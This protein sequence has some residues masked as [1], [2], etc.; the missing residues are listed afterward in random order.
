MPL[1]PTRVVNPRLGTYFSI[2]ASGFATLVLVLL[3]LEQLGASDTLIRNVMLLGPLMLYT[4]VGVS[5]STREPFDFFTSGRRVP[6]VFNGLVVAVT[7]AGAT[8]VVAGTGLFFLNGFDAWC[9]VIGLTGGLVVMSVL[10]AP[11]IR[12]F[13]AFTVP[14]YLGRRFESRAVRLAAAA[15]IS[16]PMLLVIAAEFRM[17]IYAGTWLSGQSEGLVSLILI[18]AITTAIIGGGMRSASWSNTSQS[19]ATLMAL[20]VPVGMVA[21]AVTNLP[22]APLSHGP[23]MRV[24]DR[25]ERQQGLPIP[26]LSPFT[27]NLAGS[28]L[29]PIVHR[30][31]A[32]FGSVGSLSFVIAS[33]TLMAGIAVAPWLLTRAGTTPSVYATRKS[34]GWAVFI[35][36][37]IMLIVSSVAVF[38][39]DLVMDTLVGL[40]PADLPT[41][42]RA[43]EA[44]GL[45]SVQGQMPRLPLGSFSIDRDAV[46][47]ALPLASGYPDVVVY[48]ALAGAIAAAVG[49]ASMASLALGTVLSED[50]VNGLK[51]EPAPDRLRLI[52]ARGSIAIAVLF[53][54][55]LALIAPAD[56]LQLLLWA[57][58]LS[59]STL[60]PVITLSI[61]S[62]WINASGAFFGMIT[63]FSV[64]VFAIIAGE[65][66][67]LGLH[68]SLAAAFG[69]P[70]G[71]IATIVASLMR[72]SS[73]RH[74]MELLR[75]IRVP[76]GETVHDRE[77]R[78]LRLKQRQ[79]P[80][81][82]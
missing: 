64:G 28:G 35:L 71:F 29:E 68:S 61:W 25:L 21:T 42:F 69:I 23:V 80:L 39:R 4:A 54:C 20:V 34:L 45:A 7:T 59:G 78:L 75:E 81:V 15:M 38:M 11:F 2:F 76:G 32:P 65:A 36:G 37:M 43:L 22:F 67:W 53:G 72:P 52:T 47:F 17:G 57:I 46:L 62:K 30:F 27:F 12:K 14:S 18:V 48:L 73:S 50:V 13:G 79:R 74:A 10:V 40:N 60:F 19:I 16:V 70:A 3:I 31:S 56:P 63:G 58:A 49:A 51:W 9:V 33:L 41:W 44:A 6:P 82:G 8:G 24:L 55:W 66:S 26:E 77:M 1:S 5:A